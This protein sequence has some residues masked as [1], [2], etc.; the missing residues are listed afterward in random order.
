MRMYV[1][2]AVRFGVGYLV[3]VLAIVPVGVCAQTVVRGVV[4]DSLGKPISEVA[5]GIIAI[6]RLRGRT[7]TAY[8]RCLGC[9]RARST[10][11]CAA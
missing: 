3:G 1:A 2:P 9:Q 8:S 11:R 7:I 10:C 4:V 6:H 5:L